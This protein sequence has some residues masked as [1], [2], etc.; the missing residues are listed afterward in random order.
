[1]RRG[2]I[3]ENEAFTQMEQGTLG[4]T[5]DSEA[6]KNSVLQIGPWSFANHLILLKS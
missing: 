2:W 5:F 3:I 6:A 1:M 4:F